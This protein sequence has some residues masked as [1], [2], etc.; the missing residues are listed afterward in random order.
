MTSPIELLNALK[1][2]RAECRSHDECEDC[3]LYVF[4]NGG[5]C[6]FKVYDVWDI[7]LLSE[8]RI[9]AYRILKEDA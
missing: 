9:T 5:E 8:P 4:G 2:I 3:P 1:V 6:A 7:P